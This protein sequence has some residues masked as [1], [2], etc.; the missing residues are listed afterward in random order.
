MRGEY[1]K[2]RKINKKF[3]VVCFDIGS[4]DTSFCLLEENQYAVLLKI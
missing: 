1:Q 2:K 4:G 3:S